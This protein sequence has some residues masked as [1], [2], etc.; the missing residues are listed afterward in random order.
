MLKYIENKNIKL[1]EK[2]GERSKG[3]GSVKEREGVIAEGV[4]YITSITNT[5]GVLIKMYYN[6]NTKGVLIILLQLLLLKGC[7][8]YI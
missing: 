3:E 1:K 4:N 8:S 7:Y 5:K 6:T 2:K